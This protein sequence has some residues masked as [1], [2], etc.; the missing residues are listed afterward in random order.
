MIYAST[1]SPCKYD[2]LLVL[3][4]PATYLLLDSGLLISASFARVQKELLVGDAP[5]AR[6]A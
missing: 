3:E 2:V 5:I 6:R 4:V 1:A